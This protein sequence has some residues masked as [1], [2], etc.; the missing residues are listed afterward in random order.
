MPA[1]NCNFR[2]GN[3]T[4]DSSQ[5]YYYYDI[6]CAFPPYA[7]VSTST[8]TTQIAGTT[9]TRVQYQTETITTTSVQPPSTQTAPITSISVQPPITEAQTITTTSIQPAKT[10]YVTTTITKSQ[11][12][13]SISISTIITT[14][15]QR[16]S[17]TTQIHVLSIPVPTVRSSIVIQR[18]TVTLSV[19]TTKQLPGVTMIRT[20]TKTVTKRA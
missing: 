1:S 17:T 11:T 5:P 18:V 16:I 8:V 12:S 20:S 14:V 3:F 2:D 6:G 10:S 9:I 19:T 7:D 13:T 4:T 15:V